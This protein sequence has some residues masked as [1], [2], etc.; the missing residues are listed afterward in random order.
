MNCLDENY[1]AKIMVI[2]CYTRQPFTVSVNTTPGPQFGLCWSH[3][4]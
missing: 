3:V 1:D 4:K 2:R